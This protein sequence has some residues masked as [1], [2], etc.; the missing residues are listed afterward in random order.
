[1]GAVAVD[2]MGGDLAPVAIVQGAVDC[3]RLDQIPVILVGD[4]AAIKSL[5]V[6]CGASS[7]LDNSMLSIVQSEGAIAMEEKPSAALRKKGSSMHVACDLVATGTACGALSAGNSGAMMAIAT[8]QI[9]R[10]EGVLRP[11]IA[12]LFPTRKGF[13]VVTD[14]GANV[15]CSPEMLAQFARLGAAFSK[16]FFGI[17]NPRVAVISNGEEEGKGTDLTRATLAIIRSSDIL[18]EGYCEGRDIFEGRVDVAV[19]DG[20]TGNVLLKTA[21]GTAKHFARSIK[22]A[23]QSSNLI[24]RLGAL[25]MRPAFNRVKA[26][27]DP[28]E[29][30]AAPLLGLKAPV[31]IAHGNSDA[32]AIRKAIQ[33]VARSY[34]GNVTHITQR[35]IS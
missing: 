29:Y 22:E 13:C 7:L 26:K 1:M 10:I 3:A 24:V 27:M 21:E 5:I 14:A 25:L 15:D 18:C 16:A 31:F 19:C 20:F 4:E 6:K 17:E 11:A 2:A 32:Y 23:V 12:A 33:F 34:Q 8:L 9:G 35:T 28:R 30:G